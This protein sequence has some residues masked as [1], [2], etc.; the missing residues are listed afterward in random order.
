MSRRIYSIIAIFAGLLLPPIGA[1]GEQP[2]S[3]I[4]KPVSVTTRSGA[5]TLR[6][7][8]QIFSTNTK[9]AQDLADYIAPATGY[10]LQITRNDSKSNIIRINDDSPKISAEGYI[11]IVTPNSI[12]ISASTPA[13]AFHGIQTLRQLLPPEI[14]SQTKI[15]NESWTIPAV[16]IEDYPRFPWRGLMLDCS[17]HFFTKTFIEKLLDLMALHKMNSFHWHL[18]D[19]Q[20]WRIEIKK[21]PDLTKVGAWR[22]ETVIGNPDKKGTLL[23]FD[24]TPYGGFYTQADI[25]EIVQYAADRYINV[26]PEIE[27]PGHSAAAI[28]SYPSLGC[29]TRPVEVWTSWGVNRNLLNPED[30]T[31]S[32]YKDV[33]T[34]V[35][36]LFPSKYI[37]L[38]G[39]EVRTTQWDRSPGVQARIK[40]LGL[41]ES[42]DLQP[43]MLRQLAQ[44]LESHNRRVVGWDEILADNLPPDAV[45]MSWHGTKAGIAAAKEGNDVVM[46]PNPVFYLD[47]YQSHNKSAEPITQNAVVTLSMVY[48]FDPTPSDLTPAESAHILGAQCQLWTEYVP[49]EKLAD[50]QIFPRLCAVAE[51][52]W[53]PQ[54]KKDYTDFQ[55]RL[56]THLVRLDELQI[57]YRPPKPTDNQ[58]TTKPTTKPQLDG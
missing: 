53:T 51:D 39:D 17:R 48:A 40:Q 10:S 4:P 41:K 8:T 18:T 52:T 14:F 45:I 37:H 33:L 25:R 7:D 47:H 58:T 21:Y 15:P 35:L 31:I 13:G 6:P 22:K 34:E 27:F 55:S 20:G 49:T 3:I 24:H 19:D 28:A 46:A 12:S 1:R 30:S 9:L 26:V 56:N 44:F 29:T 38:G 42:H 43:W 57:N 16:Q 32:F 5:F 23:I 54:D 11:L 36:D 50:Y 2:V